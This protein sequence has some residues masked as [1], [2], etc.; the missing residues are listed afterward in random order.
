[1]GL[2]PI[3]P[4]LRQLVNA[5]NDV[6]KVSVVVPAGDELTVSDEVAGQ[7]LAARVGFREVAEPAPA[8]TVSV[9]PEVDADAPK[10]K[11]KK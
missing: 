2:R 6:A 9:E 4:G 8:D 7:L 11:G 5:S 3:E 1:M 10:A